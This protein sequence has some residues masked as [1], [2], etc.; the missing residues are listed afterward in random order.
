MK[1]N[2]DMAVLTSSV[3]VVISQNVQARGNY[4][5]G[6][7]YYN[8]SICHIRWWTILSRIAPEN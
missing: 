1:Y 4:A 3:F 6:R 2:G 8:G 7:K 5:Q